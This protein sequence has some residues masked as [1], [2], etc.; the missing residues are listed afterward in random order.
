M[1]LTEDFMKLLCYKDNFQLRPLLELNV[2]KTKSEKKV[3][4]IKPFFGPIQNR[5]SSLYSTTESV[6]I[7]FSHIIL[8]K[9]TLTIFLPWISHEY[10]EEKILFF[11]N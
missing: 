5:F 1:N 11:A 2:M 4:R 8:G 10:H 3:G 9:A 6:L 7:M